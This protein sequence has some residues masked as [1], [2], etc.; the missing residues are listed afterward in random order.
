[1]TVDDKPPSN[2]LMN[3]TGQLPSIVDFSVLVF[4]SVSRRVDYWRRAFSQN[5]GNRQ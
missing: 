4:Y 2:T 1:M 5:L 3:L